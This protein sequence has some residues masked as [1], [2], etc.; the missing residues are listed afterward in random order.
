[1]IYLTKSGDTI[2]GIVDRNG[3]DL[4]DMLCHNDIYLRDEQI[5]VFRKK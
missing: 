4:E 1:M 3:I 5:I 2:Q